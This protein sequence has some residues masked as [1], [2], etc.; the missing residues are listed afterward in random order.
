MAQQSLIYSFVSRGT[1]ILADHTDFTGNF[2]LIA[3]Q[4]LEKLPTTNNKFTYNCDRHTFNYLVEDG[5]TYGVVAEESVGRQ[6]PMAFLERIKEDFKKRYSGG[7]AEIAISNSLNKEFG[8]KLKEHMD[9]CAE[10]PE[11]ITKISR[12]KAQVSEV[13]G[14]M[15]ENIEK[16][17]DRGE[18]ISVMVDRADNLRTEAEDFR[19]TVF[20]VRGSLLIM[21]YVLLPR[22]NLFKYLLLYVFLACYAK[23]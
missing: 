19:R 16:V 3:Y 1:A 5:F 4:C 15:M 11:E 14:V 12:V 21:V 10:H 23:N 17:I 8:P 18:T 13:K 20:G 6:V 22:S 7:R 2:T 9:Y